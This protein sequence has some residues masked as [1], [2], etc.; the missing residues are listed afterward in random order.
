MSPKN[1]N[2]LPGPK[3]IRPVSSKQDEMKTEKDMPVNS[4]QDE[5]KTEKDMPVSSKHDE[6]KTEKIIHFFHYTNN[7]RY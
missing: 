6:V 5:V 2:L 7:F 3:K 4:K 1:Q